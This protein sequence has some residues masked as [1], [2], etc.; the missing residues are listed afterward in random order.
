MP[1]NGE[2]SK[3]LYNNFVTGDGPATTA[4]ANMYLDATKYT[5]S[6]TTFAIVAQSGTDVGTGQIHMLQSFELEK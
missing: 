4:L 6:N 1:M 5:P 2:T 3:S